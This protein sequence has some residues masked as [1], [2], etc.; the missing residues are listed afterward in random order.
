MLSSSQH[1]NFFSCAGVAIIAC[2]LAGEV[3]AGTYG[4]DAWSPIQSP[5]NKTLNQLQFLDSLTGWVVGDSGTI[6]H[7]STGGAIWVLQKSRV[8]EDIR[9]IFML[10]SSRGWAVA[11]DTDG[12][13][14]GSI[15][16]S[17]TDGGTTWTDQRYPV[18]EEFFNSIMFLDSL[19]G[20]MVGEGGRIVGT[21]NAG[22]TWF[23][24]TVDSNAAPQWELQRVKFY[25]PSLGFA[26]GGRFDIVGT[27]WRTT[28]GGAMWAG[29]SVSLE[30]IYD[31]HFFDS[32]HIIGI[33][34]DYDFGSGMI[35]TTDGGTTWEY[36][37]LGIWGQASAISFR[38]PYEAWTPQGFATT[39][40]YSLDKGRTW[41]D[42]PIPGFNALYDVQ[43]T[44]SL[45]GYM[46]GGNGTILKFNPGTVSVDENE[47]TPVSSSL[48]TA[49]P[50]PFNP[51]TTI[52]YELKAASRV[53]LRVFDILG[54]EIRELLSEDQSAG[55]HSIPMGSDGLASGVYLCRLDV[56][57]KHTRIS[58]STTTKLLLLR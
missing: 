3:S 54:R 42:T 29:Q 45:H 32:L 36:T 2:L 53:S 41:T 8:S 13:Q 11:Q 6:L 33:G 25:S 58:S 20:W 49:F 22:N 9:D 37:Y 19:R 50:N 38:T 43:F 30:P 35:T 14:Y 46:V 47:I 51:S 56:V 31:L 7:T 15:V 16:L 28:N 17:T 40:M 10:N 27:V 26:V 23:N 57:E 44:D 18:Q 34:G 21:T 39:A 4:P 48:V 55:R 5:T 12:P 52:S 24:A 1:K